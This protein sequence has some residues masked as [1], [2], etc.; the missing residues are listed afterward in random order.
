MSINFRSRERK[1][2]EK[3]ESLLAFGHQKMNI[4]YKVTQETAFFRVAS[5]SDSCKSEAFLISQKEAD[6]V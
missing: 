1:N 5:T 2:K 6:K 3:N 4:F